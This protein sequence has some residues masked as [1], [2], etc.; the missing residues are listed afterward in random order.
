[1]LAAIGVGAGALREPPINLPPAPPPVPLAVPSRP[2]VE[3]DA[4]LLQPLFNPA[5]KPAKRDEPPTEAP[6][7]TPPPAL[8]GVVIEEGRRAA[9]LEDASGLE[10]RRVRAGQ[11]FS[12][13]QLDAIHRKHVVLSAGGQRLVIELSYQPRS[14]ASPTP[15]DTPSP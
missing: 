2:S 3:W 4:V 5:R 13:W 9:L 1:L 12:G 14:N 6:A 8:V 10:R 7:S 11:T 15:P